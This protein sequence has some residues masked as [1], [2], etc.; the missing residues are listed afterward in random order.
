LDGTVQDAQGSDEQ[1]KL[2]KTAFVS[3]QGQQAPL[4]QLDP[5]DN[6]KLKPVHVDKLML[7][8]LDDFSLSFQSNYSKFKEH[9]VD[10][11]FSINASQDTSLR[12]QGAGNRRID[13]YQQLEL[14]TQYYRPVGLMEKPDFETDSFIHVKFERK[15]EALTSI[16]FD[17]HMLVEAKNT[18]T[19][20]ESKTDTEFSF[21]KVVDRH[22]EG[23]NKAIDNDFVT[24]LKQ[25][26][27]FELLS[28]IDK[29][30]LGQPFSH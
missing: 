16:E 17:D 22:S 4:T 10:E 6:P 2:I 23:T 24:Q 9:R 5:I 12:E 3:L 29:I 14:K 11:L 28:L 26:S 20:D 15:L 19:L 25:E 30:G 8:G 21:G 27:N 7:T 18:Q 13:K 1:A